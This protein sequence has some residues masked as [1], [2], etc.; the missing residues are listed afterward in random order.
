MRTTVDI[1]DS[2]Y[3]LLKAKAAQE[4]STVKTILL[5]SVDRELQGDEPKPRLRLKMPILKSKRPGTLDL[6]NERIYDLIGF[7]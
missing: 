2:R 7:P 3:R 6:D 1:P 5:R 4:G